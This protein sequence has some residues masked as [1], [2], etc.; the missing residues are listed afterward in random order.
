MFRWRWWWTI[1]VRDAYGPTSKFGR[2]LSGMARDIARAPA[3]GPVENCVCSALEIWEAADRGSGRTINPITSFTQHLLHLH[4][5]IFAEMVYVVA[6]CKRA[7]CF[8]SLD[9]NNL[10]SDPLLRAPGL[11]CRLLRLR[12]RSKQ[13]FRGSN[14]KLLHTSIKTNH[15]SFCLA[16]EQRLV[17]LHSTHKVA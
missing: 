14:G 16:S 2:L 13:L 1:R 5:E 12:C 11:D 9:L 3:L 15:V 4:D 7:L 6:R 17:V 10:V 8:K